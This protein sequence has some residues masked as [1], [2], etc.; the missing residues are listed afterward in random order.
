MLRWPP[1]MAVKAAWVIAVIASSCCRPGDGKVHQPGLQGGRASNISAAT[2]CADEGCIRGPYISHRKQY[3]L[4]GLAG[5][6]I[7]WRRG[8]GAYTGRG[9][10]CI[11]GVAGAGAAIL[12]GWLRRVLPSETAEIRDGEVSESHTSGLLSML[13]AGQMP[14]GMCRR[15]CGGG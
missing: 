15:R 14:T 13:H 3:K 9:S 10:G 8:G 1:N 12:L 2:L 5:Q 7:P 6:Q 4:R 11:A